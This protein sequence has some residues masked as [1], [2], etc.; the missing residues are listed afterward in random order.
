[1]KNAILFIALLV[2]KLA[3][4]FFSLYLKFLGLNTFRPFAN[5]FKGES[6]SGFAI[7]YTP[8]TPILC[9]IAIGIY[10]LVLLFF[11][12]RKVHLK[13]RVLLASILVVLLESAIVLLGFSGIG[14]Q[15]TSNWWIVLGVNLLFDLAMGLFFGRLIYQLI[16]KLSAGGVS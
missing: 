14:I 8:E 3:F 11:I 7:G 13:Q 5:H 1:M 6:G 10:V 9:A 4:F 2:A 16:K 12:A 15:G